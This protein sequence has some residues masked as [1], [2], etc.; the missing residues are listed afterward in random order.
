[1][2]ITLKKET[3]DGWINSIY[4]HVIEDLHDLHAPGWL[5]AILFSYLSGRTMTMTYGSSTSTPRQLPGSSPQGALLGGLIFI[6]KYNGA[7]LRPMI[8]RILLSLSQS[9][10]VKYVDDHSSA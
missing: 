7:C 5:L 8:P 6:V 1:M 4:M 10:S 3:V 2:H 9:I